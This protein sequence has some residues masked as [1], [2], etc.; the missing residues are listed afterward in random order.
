MLKNVE[1]C[2]GTNAEPHFWESTP[3]FE[4]MRKSLAVLFIGKFSLSDALHLIINPSLTITFK[5]LSYI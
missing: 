4:K 2:D 1:I 5:H 3:K